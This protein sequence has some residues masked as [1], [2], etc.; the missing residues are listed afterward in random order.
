MKLFLLSCLR[1]IT[2]RMR[3]FEFALVLA[4]N[5]NEKKKTTY[6]NFK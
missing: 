3:Q 6:L 2:E 4:L 5:Q 1:F